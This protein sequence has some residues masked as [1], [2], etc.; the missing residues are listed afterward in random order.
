MLVPVA[1]LLLVGPKHPFFAQYSLTFVARFMA[2][3]IVVTAFSYFFE[4]TRESNHRE[5]RS[6]NQSLE[7]TV[8]EKT[9]EMTDLR[10]KELTIANQL[11]EADICNRQRTEMILKE[12]EK[13]Y[14]SIVGNISDLIC[15]HDLEGRILETNLH[16][17]KEIGYSSGELIGH[18][19]EDLIEKQYRAAFQAYLKEFPQ[20][21]TDEGIFSIRTKTGQRRILEYSNILVKD[22]EGRYVIQGF[23]KDITKRWITE[24]ALETSEKRYRTLFEKAGDAIFILDASSDNWGAIINANQS[25]AEMHGY[26]IEEL[27]R[28]NIKDLVASEYAGGVTSQFKEMMSGK[29]IKAEMDQVR[30]D[31]RCF[32]VEVSAGMFKLDDRPYIL[33]F[34][35]DITQRREMEE[36]LRRTEK[37]EALGTLSGGIAHDFNNVLMGIQGHVSLMELYL[38]SDH[39]LKKHSAAIGQYV[40]SAADLTKQLLGLGRGG[41][42]EVRPVE[43]NELLT[44]TAEMFGRTRKDIPIHVRT[45]PLPLVVEADRGQI[46]QVLLNLM[47][48]ACQAM[49]KGG[50]LIIET[51]FVSLDD[52]SS[53]V[54]Q[55]NPGPYAQVSVKD[56]GIGMNE[57]TMRRVFDPFFTTKEKERGTGLGLSSAFGIVKNHDGTIKVESAIGKGTTFEVLIPLSD[58]T[59]AA[60]IQTSNILATGSET[61]LLV[62]DEEMVIKGCEAM[63]EH[64]GYCVIVAQGGSQAVE[65]VQQQGE[66]ID[67]VILDLIMPGMNGSIAFDHIRILR[68]NIPILLSSGYAMEGQAAEMMQKG[69]NG[70]IQKPFGIIELSQKVRSL[71]DEFK[72]PKYNGLNEALS[73]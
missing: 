3:Y 15:V 66:R 49:P 43:L 41:K 39:P 46:E 11:L 62:D 5:L 57:E 27:E 35:R 2:A 14:R 12:R 64:C 37:M 13:K 70:F 7:S 47:L 1:G 58:K 24:K 53:K 72:R 18:K 69:C 54:C 6:I 61:I 55:L 34:Y 68:E 51:A 71:L 44:A 29:W 22:A 45:H 33:A 32:L 10:T 48:N 17:K 65:T 56:S 25:S 23:A 73:R 59:P 19:I 26:S 40:Q 38:S 16:Y 9:K 21:G 67:L 42:Y 63:L 31:G 50:D 36:R 52:N 20:K 28:L 4:R 8:K 60:K 30:K